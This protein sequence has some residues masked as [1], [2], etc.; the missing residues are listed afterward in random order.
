MSE[1]RRKRLFARVEQAAA[2]DPRRFSSNE[3]VTSVGIARLKTSFRP[4]AEVESELCCRRTMGLPALDANCAGARV[5]RGDKPCAAVQDW[6]GS[7]A[8]GSVR[9]RHLHSGSALTA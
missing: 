1:M 4:V 5:H 7:P 8:L 9:D 6:C 2:F 3:H